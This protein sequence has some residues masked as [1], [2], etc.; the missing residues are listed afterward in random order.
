MI[1]SGGVDRLRQIDD[2]RTVSCHQDVEFGKV[3]V[4][5][6]GRE[7]AHELLKQHSVMCAR[8]LLGQQD[9]VEPRRGFAVLIGH[10]FHQ[11]DAVEEVERLRHTDTGRR[12]SVQRIDLVTLPR[13]FGRLT[14]KTGALGHR[15]SLA[16]VL[17]LAIFGVVD[18][19]PEAAVDRFFVDFRAAHV[20]SATNDVDSRF[21]AAHQLAYD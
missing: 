8:G 12:Q 11:Q 18:R 17:G 14:A 21:L 13:C 19:L 20:V 9:I 1:V 5:D 7:H 3:A 4:D 15:P 6:P 2:D 10:Q 16:R